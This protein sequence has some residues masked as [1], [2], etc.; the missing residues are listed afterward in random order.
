MRPLGKRRCDLPALLAAQVWVFS[1]LAIFGAS[2][3]SGI[4]PPARALASRL[5]RADPSPANLPRKT[6][7][8]LGKVV[9]PLEMLEPVN[10]WLAFR[11]QPNVRQLGYAPDN[12]EVGRFEVPMNERVLMRFPAAVPPPLDWEPPNR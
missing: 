6:L 7:A 11:H 3:A 5:A 2:R 1:S 8:G 9:T 4:V 10:G 12:N